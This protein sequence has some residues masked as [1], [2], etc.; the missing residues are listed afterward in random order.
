MLYNVAL[1]S[2]VQHE[3]AINIRISLLSLPATPDPTPPFIFLIV[4]LKHTPFSCIYLFT[5]WVCIAARRPLSS[6]SVRASH[7]G[8]FSFCGAQAGVHVGL[9]SCCTG[10]L[11]LRSSQT[12]ASTRSPALAG[13]FLTTGPQGKSKIFDS[14]EV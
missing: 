9:S 10:L 2:A 11:A 3:S 6:C 13:G 8:G 1:A 12:R 5:C 7:H 14:D 4:S